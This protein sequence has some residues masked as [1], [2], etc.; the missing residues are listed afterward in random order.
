MAGKRVAFDITGI[1]EVKRA[2]AVDAKGVQAA[3]DRAIAN[4]TNDI[5]NRADQ[6]VPLDESPLRTSGHIKIDRGQ[7]GIELQ[8]VY[9]GAAESY[10]IVQHE[11][12]DFWHPPK[13]PS[14][15]KSGGRQGTG[16]GPDPATGRGPKYL[17]RPFLEETKNL[18]QK[19]VAQVRAEFFGGAA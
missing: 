19:I 13:P 3:A 9:G 2:L 1:R 18:R 6:L 7:Y 5:F 14:K 8:I 12:M 17:E 11:R 4:V 10:A 16:P 15:Q